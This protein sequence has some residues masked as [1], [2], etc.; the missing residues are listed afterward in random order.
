MRGT[1][2]S[3]SNVLGRR[4]FAYLAVGIALAV[5]MAA[6]VVALCLYEPNLYLFTYYAFDYSTGFVRRGLAGELVSLF[7][8]TLYFTVQLTLRWLVPAVVVVGLAAVAWTAAVRFGRSERRLMLALLV[9]VLPF[10]F[11]GVVMIPTPTI[12]GQAA[13]AGLAV[14]LASLS[15]RPVRDRSILV[16]CGAYGFC[17][18]VLALIHEAIPLLFSLGAVLAAVTLVRGSVK[19]QRV[20]A[21]LAVTP[22]LAASLLVGLLGRRDL[23]P[24]CARLPHRFMEWPVSMGQGQILGQKF[25]IDYNE[26]VCTYFVP[27]LNASPADG[28]K[29]NVSLGALPWIESAVFGVFIC[30]I[31]IL[32][33]RYISG[34]PFKRFLSLLAQRRLWVI[35]GA[36]LFIPLFAASSDWIRW[37][38]AI[39]FNV[40]AIYLLYAS[41]QPESASQPN[42]RTRILFTVGMILLAFIPMGTVVQVSSNPKSGL[43][44][45][46]HGSQAEPVSRAG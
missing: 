5:Y 31:T 30:A 15:V 18:A 42:R 37:W 34:V 40:G 21:L 44:V 35:F 33:I 7:P 4:R 6:W 45:K 39:S 41:K 2:V 29:S 11:A 25:Y 13:L 32:V 36:I 43:Q 26:F 23:S 27:V 46:P 14:T 16:A 12:L 17:T 38:V 9:P 24:Q 10:G 19:I 3:P 28:F 20:S 8:A 1:V 22:G